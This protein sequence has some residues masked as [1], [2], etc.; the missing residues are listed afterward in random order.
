MM[1]GISAAYRLPRGMFDMHAIGHIFNEPPEAVRRGVVTA[2][3]RPLKA[4][5][6]G[7]GNLTSRIVVK[8]LAE[9][10]WRRDDFHSLSACRR[11]YLR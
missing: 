11:R 7:R 10:A 2:H 8:L 1:P 5:H 6:S 9:R 4:T 3:P